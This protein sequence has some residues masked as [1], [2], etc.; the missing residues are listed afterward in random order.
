MK[1]WKVG[2]LAKMSGLSVRTLHFYEEAG[3]LK[4][5]FRTDSHHRLYN[6]TDVIRLQQIISL[7]QLGL[8]L[9]MIKKCLLMD[10][11]TPLQ[12]TEMHL[13]FVSDERARL[14][15]LHRLLVRLDKSLKEQKEVSIEN[16]INI[17][18]ALRMYDKY[19][20][21]EQMH[22][23]GERKREM[24][25]EKI[26]AVQSEWAE[27][28]AKVRGEMKAGTAAGDPRVQQMARRWN[29]LIEAFTGGNPEIRG[30]LREMYKKEPAIRQKSGIDDELNAYVGKMMAYMLTVKK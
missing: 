25:T 15:E 12:V 17:M 20:N 4:P 9:E 2:D 23:L 19:F 13:R 24:G 21:E 11:L 10:E 29:E 22:E 16:F 30:K 18:E 3:L 1:T 27:L 14:E 8:S 26:E 28:I 7:K 5:S 6:E